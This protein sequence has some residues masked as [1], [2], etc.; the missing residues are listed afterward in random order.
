MAIG[1]SGGLFEP[2]RLA[3][4]L[5]L[6]NA[7]H[8]GEK[9]LTSLGVGSL[10][11]LRRL[12]AGRLTGGGNA[13]GVTHPVIE[14]TLLP[15]SPYEAFVPGK[16]NDVPLLIGANADEARAL[17]DVSRTTAVSLASD[18]ESSF[19]QLPPAIIAAYSQSTDEAARRARPDLEHDLRFGWDMWAR[20]RLH[21]TTRRSAIDCHSFQ[22]QPPFP[23]DF[24]QLWYVF[25]HLNQA[26][27][28]WIQ[29][30]RALSQD[31]PRYWSNFAKSGDP[32]G[33]GL[34]PWPAFSGA[35]G[36][37]LYRGGPA[38][39]N[40]VADLESPTVL[41][42]STRQFAGSAS[43]SGNHWDADVP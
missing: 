31:M 39:A 20:A 8:D 36:K 11:E 16:Q 27:W 2:L 41:T 22:Q 30:D 18:I 26:P 1:E 3:P 35:P 43:A 10:E 5:L 28:P 42:A 24:A 7:E 32:N 17:T 37:V 38:S 19:G 40:G 34:A 4:N 15:K 25:D 6:A 33:P 23:R 29:R 13:G 14:P 9:S 12:T 21:A